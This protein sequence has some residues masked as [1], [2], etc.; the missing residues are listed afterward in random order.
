MASPS[1]G[2]ITRQVPAAEKGVEITRVKK[3]ETWRFAASGRWRDWFITCGPRG[4]HNFAADAL[5]IYPRVEDA[6]WF[7]LV[8]KVG[9]ET[10]II[11]QGATHT[12]EAD[13][14]LVVFANDLQCLY[15]NNAGEITLTAWQPSDDFPS[16]P[17]EASEPQGVAGAW[18]LLRRT[19][20]KTTGV[21]VVAA[22]VIGGCL[23]LSMMQQ[24]PDLVPTPGEDQFDLAKPSGWRQFGFGL[25]LLVMGIQA[26]LWP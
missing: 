14:A 9:D 17:P 22:L 12:F 3:G 7:C 24:G 21:G 2:A 23:I 25:T 6:P 15:G 5:E 10:I 11:G 8:G 20:D 16:P 26:W 19:L 4:Y 1:N 13:G 18:A